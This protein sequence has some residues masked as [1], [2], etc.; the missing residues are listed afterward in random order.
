MQFRSVLMTVALITSAL[1]GP[2]FQR[3]PR[4]IYYSNETDDS[5]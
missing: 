1:A 4:T 5:T 2:I 3:K